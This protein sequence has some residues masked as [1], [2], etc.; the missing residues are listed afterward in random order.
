MI[1]DRSL[2]R[3]LYRIA[4]AY[5][6]DG[7]TQQQVADRFG[8]SRQKVSRLLRQ[9][10]RE[11]IVNITVVPPSG[12]MADLE[13]ELERE[14]GLQEAVVVRVSDPQDELAVARELGPAAAECLVRSISGR[15]IVGMTW[16][17]AMLAMV[18]ALP[19]RSWPDVTIVQMTGGLGLVDAREH[20]AELTRRVAQRLGAKLRLLPAPGIVSTA[21]VAQALTAEPQV[22]ETLALAASADVATVGLGVPS[23]DS[24]LL[25]D[26]TIVGPDY[27][28]LLKRAG[29]VG[30]V[31]LRNIDRH[32]RP[33]DLEISNR[34]IG[35]TLE[36][37]QCIPRV[38][39]VA[40]GEPKLEMIRAALRGKILD[41]LVTD[42]VTAQALATE[43]E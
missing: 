16:G 7:L 21:A 14:Y 13:R 38:I 25:R 10:R 1:Q 17:R 28:E 30:D 8:L 18:D 35:L 22:A 41:V 9:A 31:G 32:G 19:A 43:T 2:H 33:V 12:G 29:T 39:G 4:Q 5:Y 6:D 36:Q 42:H 15:E 3:L 23:P 34:I 20:S 26:G 11:R 40:G 27:L 37:I 24:I